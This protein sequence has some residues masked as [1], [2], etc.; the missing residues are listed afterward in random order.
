LNKSSLFTTTT[1]IMAAAAAAAGKEA[2]TTSNG[3]TNS[4]S[5]SS[6]DIAYYESH[7]NLK[8]LCN[9][10]RSRQGPAVREALLMDRRVHYIKGTKNRSLAVVVF[11][12]PF[13]ARFFLNLSSL[14]LAK[15]TLRVLITI[16]EMIILG[17]KLV[18]FLVEPKK[19]TKWPSKLPRLNSR[20]DAIAVCKN[21]I[22]EQFLVRTDKAGKGE[23]SVSSTICICLFIIYGYAHVGSLHSVFL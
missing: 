20:Q 12:L 2:A 9:F 22:K 10:L 18:N 4:T 5:T 21:L 1:T 23:L 15:L 3:K 13:L 19:G 14:A 17:E 6:S 7:E 8:K 16:H 11:L